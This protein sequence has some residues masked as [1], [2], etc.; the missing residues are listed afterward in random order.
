MVGLI[1]IGGTAIFTL[2]LPIWMLLSTYYQVGEHELKVRCGPFVWRIDRSSIQSIKP[3]RTL[4]SSPA[5]SLDRLEIRYGDHRS[6]MV[7][8]LSREAF[9]EDLGVSSK[10]PDGQAH[11]E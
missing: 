9:I 7:S 8:P 4:L 6:I 5:L 10:S 3:S 1:I 2:G 11:L